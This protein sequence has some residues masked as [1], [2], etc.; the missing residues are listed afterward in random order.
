MQKMLPGIQFRLSG[1]LWAVSAGG[2]LC[3]WMQSQ[4]S[5]TH[6]I[7]DL[8]RQQRNSGTEARE[9]AL[10]W[11]AYFAEQ[12]GGNAMQY[13]QAWVFVD[14]QERPVRDEDLLRIVPELKALDGWPLSTPRCLALF[15]SGVTEEYAEQLRRALPSWTLITARKVSVQE[16]EP[17]SS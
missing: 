4:W 17:N 7:Q 11:I 1:L 2:L 9:R 13:D 5:L 15:G 14:L 3:A 16:V 10:H 6:T 12:H 8:E